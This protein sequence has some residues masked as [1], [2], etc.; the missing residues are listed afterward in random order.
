[1]LADLLDGTPLSEGTHI[2]EVVTIRRGRYV[3][4]KL[5]YR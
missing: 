2:A 5:K 3:K 4:H 1:V